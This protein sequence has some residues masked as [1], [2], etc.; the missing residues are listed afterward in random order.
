MTDSNKNNKIK[1]ESEDIQSELR[2][3]YNIPKIEVTT[4]SFDNYTLN[5][6]TDESHTESNKSNKGSDISKLQ[7][8][9]ID[10]KLEV[11]MK[12]IENSNYIMNRRNSVL[13][14]PDKSN[15][16]TKSFDFLAI[17]TKTNHF[18]SSTIPLKTPDSQTP[19][20]SDNISKSQPNLIRDE[21]ESVKLQDH[22][23]KMFNHAFSDAIYSPRESWLATVFNIYHAIIL[24]LSF[25]LECYSTQLMTQD[26]E[27]ERRAWR[28]V[29]LVFTIQLC[30]YFL[31]DIILYPI[32]KRRHL[33]MLEVTTRNSQNKGKIIDYKDIKVTKN[34]FKLYK[35]FFNIPH[36][37]EFLGCLPFFIEEIFPQ[38]RI[39]NLNHY[40]LISFFLMCCRLY[41]CLSIFYYLRNRISKFF[42]IVIRAIKDSIYEIISVIIL[43]FIVMIFCSRIIFYAD[44]SKCTLDEA[45]QNWKRQYKNGTINEESLS[46]QLQSN[47]DAFWY[48]FMTMTTLGFGDQTPN[49]YFGK[50]MATVAFGATPILY[51][52]PSIVITTKMITLIIHDTRSTATKDV[53]KKHKRRFFNMG[54]FLSGAGGHRRNKFSKLNKKTNI[55]NS[56][57]KNAKKLSGGMDTNAK[58]NKSK[59]VRSKK[60]KEKDK[61]VEKNRNSKDKG[62]EKI[63]VKLNDKTYE[64]NNN[65]DKR[66]KIL[67]SV[68]HNKK[69]EFSIGSSI[70][71]LISNSNTVN[72]IDT[73]D[74]KDFSFSNSNN[75]NSNSN[76]NSNSSNS[77]PKKDNSNINNDS[78][79]EENKSD[80]IS[81]SQ[82]LNESPELKNE[83]EFE[84]ESKKEIE[85]PIMYE[86]PKE[87]G[88][89]EL[90][91]AIINQNKDMLI[92]NN[93]SS[94]TIKKLP[95]DNSYS[96]SGKPLTSIF[97]NPESGQIY[98]ENETSH[99]PTSPSAST[100]NLNNSNSYSNI[101]S[102]NKSH[103]KTTFKALPISAGSGSTSE[104]ENEST[105]FDYN[106]YK[107]NASNKNYIVGMLKQHYQT[108]LEEIDYVKKREKTLNS[109]KSGFEK[110]IMALQ[111]M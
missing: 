71:P 85:P 109:L 51:S 22:I 59:Y 5:K 6:L 73:K 14:I 50:I 84:S 40:G 46:C 94:V 81:N 33:A 110:G 54:L 42:H 76:S 1:N 28:I 98:D 20:K 83:I 13:R 9:F 35:G 69:D 96:S 75:N 68:P 86:S 89:S 37:M 26:T 30:L 78:Q 108:C 38:C 53:V 17:D 74:S 55:N 10:P 45:S 34:I 101:T 7:N 52:L 57:N 107:K 67:L 44:L 29:S 61:Y 2:K 32:R 111:T 8:L 23:S 90:K 36:T 92:S 70:S 97:E 99:P 93:L 27:L 41:T 15:N 82:Q 79:E 19:L 95:K 100:S 12:D 105:I 106:A 77:S 49:T 62:K 18:Q 39:I 104:T 21:S 24:Y 3:K 91:K 60:N 72:S 102:K 66:K 48:T 11:K 80:M 58:D 4:T 63:I 31:A 47:L 64:S 43:Y 56:S 88:D 25:F 103:P 87:I 16:I 65:E